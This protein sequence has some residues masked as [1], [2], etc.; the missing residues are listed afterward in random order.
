MISITDYK[1]ALTNKRDSVIKL[2][3]KS[4]FQE[5]AIKLESDTQQILQ[6][7][8]PSVLFYG[9]YNSGKSTLINAI[10]QEDLAKV[11]DIPTTSQTQ[12]I[13]WGDFTI[14]DTPG[15]NAKNEHTLI[16]EQE[17]HR[18]DLI[19]FVIDD[20]N[21]EEKSFYSAFVSVLKGGSNA[22]IVINEKDPDEAE[23]ENSPK[24]QK[25]K[26]R[27][28][29]NIRMECNNQKA[30][31]IEKAKNFHNIFSVNAFS[32][33]E[34]RHC[35]GDFA[36]ALY[37]SSGIDNLTLHMNKLMRSSEGV[38][39]LLPA[40][41]IMKDALKDSLEQMK[42]N[43]TDEHAKKY[44]E[45]RNRILRQRDSLYQTLLLEGKNKIQMY[46]NELYDSVLANQNPKQ[47]SVIISELESLI[48]KN[49]KSFSTELSNQIIDLYP[50]DIDKLKVNL[51]QSSIQTSAL[52]HELMDETDISFDFENFLEDGLASI[53]EL[54]TTP[55]DLTTKLKTLGPVTVFPPMPVPT[56]TIFA[57]LNG[58]CDLFLRKK[59]KEEKRQ[60]LLK[61]QM[62]LVNQANEQI[63]QQ[64]NELV[65]EI[66][67]INRKIQTELIKLEN[68]YQSCINELITKH[69]DPILQAMKE[70]YK[71]EQKE[72]TELELNSE[73]MNALLSELVH[74]E[75]EIEQ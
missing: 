37:D 52:N 14:I 13:P 56:G 68:S 18:H 45:L 51:K 47:S 17:V 6:K 57:I 46:G 7:E 67:S 1:K 20:M 74:I 75:S 49:F 8:N 71:K 4:G 21:V 16:A 11:G 35:N 39:M 59:K 29:E 28:I 19:I 48:Q 2:L 9:L 26:T 44:S 55:A 65:T 3:Q 27:I 24:I 30:E 60:K 43:H 53:G 58:I 54:L 38:K 12:E 36:K 15:I 33:C 63:E 66:I 41:R 61:E 22:L 62:E 5:K 69:F 72:Q 42:E 34:S 25:L 50:M 23:L 64:M 73:K 32:A 70:E 40:I 31:K 10:F